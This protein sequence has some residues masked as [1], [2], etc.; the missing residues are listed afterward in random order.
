MR[1]R[2]DRWITRLR[3]FLYGDERRCL[4][5]AEFRMA[6]LPCDRRLVVPILHVRRPA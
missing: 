3:R 6:V 2:L 5:V 4:F 1:A